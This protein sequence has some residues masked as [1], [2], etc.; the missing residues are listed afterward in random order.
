MKRALFSIFTLLFCIVVFTVKSQTDC[1]NPHLID[2]IPFS[3][4]GLSTAATENHYGPEDACESTAMVNNEY[5]F[6]ISPL[7]D[8][9]INVVLSG[10]SIQTSSALAFA[11]IGLFIIKSCPDDIDA[12]CI[13]SSVQTANPALFD[14]DLEGGETYYI[15]V[16]TANNMLGV[17]TSV[18]FDIGITEN[19]K[20]DV[21]VIGLFD[22]ASSCDLDQIT[23]ACEI[24]NFGI[25]ESG[26]FEVGYSVNGGGVHYETFAQTL[27]PEASAVFVFAQTFDASNVDVYYIEVFTNMITDE[28][29]SN[30]GIFDT[31]VHYP[32]YSTYPITEDFE[33]DNGYWTR[34]GTSPSWTYGSPSTE[35][36]I[37]AA[38]SGS[39]CWVTNLSG[40]AN[41]NEN[42]HITSPC[43]DLTGLVIPTLEFKIWR[44]FGLTG[45]NARVL[46]SRDGGET[47]TD[48]IRTWTN[49]TTG[50][51]HIYAEMP[52]LA[53]ETNVKFRI[54]HTS[55]FLAG[56]GVGID[57]FTVREA[58]MNDVGISK[59]TKPLSGCGLNETETV[60]VMIKN[61]GAASQT[62]IP[63]NYSADGGNTWL[64]IAEI[65]DGTLMPGDS[66]LYTFTATV[67]LSSPGVYEFH[68]KTENPGDEVS[69]NDAAIY[70][71]NSIPTIDDF[72]YEE[73]FEE[74]PA[75]W[76]AYGTNSSMQL[77]MPNGVVINSAADGDY[78]WVT[79]PNGFVNTGEVSYLQSP[80]FDFSD[81]VNPMFKAMVQYETTQILSDFTVE[82]SVDGETWDTLDAGLAP[83]NWYGDDMFGGFL[84]SW[85][86]NSGGWINVTTDMPMLA[87][88][89]NVS[90]RFA[91]NRGFSFGDN[92][93]VAIDMIVIYDCDVF[94]VADYEFEINGSVV[95]F[96]NTSQNADTYLW[97]FNENQFLPSTSTE[98][99]PVFD[100]VVDGTYFVTLTASNECSSSQMTY[101]VNIIGTDVNIVKNENLSLY[102]N[103][104]STNVFLTNLNNEKLTISIFNISGQLIELIHANSDIIE[105]N[106]E[107]YPS[108]LYNMQIINESEIHNIS[109]IK[110]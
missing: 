98:E 11:N 81:M 76:Y 61:Y 82:Y 27:L 30:D 6:E 10:T 79:N 38:F 44:S 46:A 108:G 57:D 36:T 1:S 105:L 78:A 49:S 86:G 100:F 45:N 66:V 9:Q 28:D 97:E 41:T 65:Y 47:W 40:N 107:N 63:V 89:S 2:V 7:E 24:K 21:G 3:E 87:G 55:G 5:V 43:Y 32:T 93:G 84:S 39:Y 56:N 8:I 77:G 48:T 94:P 70:I 85:S 29:N 35:A 42:S 106:I 74:G 20:F 23:I 91:Y 15:I 72:D 54:T 25:A 88:Q 80:C 26:N 12:E 59:I 13:A 99:N 83:V 64:D 109:F 60:T 58:I 31:I 68:A 73:S 75:G 33:S 95:T 71:V 92:E 103:P 14:I 16:S 17:S 22:L 18:T 101:T 110:E 52:S 90:L 19:Y 102:P 69:G 34:G 62:D 50:W 96:V 104:A 4:A 53:N 37:N 51:V 67:D